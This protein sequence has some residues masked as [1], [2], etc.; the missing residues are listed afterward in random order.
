MTIKDFSFDLIFFYFLLPCS[1][2]LLSRKMV[3]YSTNCKAC[4]LWN[5]VWC[6]AVTSMEFSPVYQGLPLI[7]IPYV[8]KSEKQ[9]AVR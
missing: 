5:A 8:G 7:L 9:K 4:L 3:C 6:C 2:M 1:K